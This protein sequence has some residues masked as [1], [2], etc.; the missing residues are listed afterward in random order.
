MCGLLCLVLGLLAIPPASPAEPILDNRQLRIRWD[1]T[2]G[3]LLEL[4]SLDQ[5]RNLIGEGADQPGL[6]ELRAQHNGNTSVLTPNQARHFLAEKPPDQPGS[7]R[8]I[9]RD[10]ARSDAPDLEIAVSVRL[11]SD[12][13]MSR[14]E[15][16]AKGLANLRLDQVSFPRVCG[17]ARQAHEMLAVPDHM[18]QLIPEPRD[19]LRARRAWDYP[20]PLSM[21][22]LAVYSVDGLGFYASSDDTEAFRKSFALECDAKARIHFQLVHY[23]E[24]QSQSAGNY[25]LPYHVELGAFRGDWLSAAEHYRD[26]ALKQPWARASRLQRGQVPEW[27]EKTAI[28]AWNRG[29]SPGVIPPAATLQ[30]AVGLPVSVFWHWWHGCAYDTGFPEY[31]P[32]REGAEPFQKALA[33]AHARQIHALVYMNQ[34]LWGMTTRSWL[35]EHAEQFAVKGPD[36]KIHPEVYNIFTRQP[37]AAMCL[38]T[39]FWRNKYARLAQQAFQD[40]GVDGIYMDQA[41]LNMTC[42]DATHGH[43]LGGGNYWMQGFHKLAADIRK[44]CMGGRTVALAGEGC[45]ETWIPDL[46]LMLTLEVSRERYQG[47]AGGAEPIPLFQAVYHPLAITFGNYSS[48]VMPPYDE[49]WPARTAPRQPMALLEPQYGRQFRLEQ[50]RAFVWGQQPTIANFQPSLLQTR[51]AETAYAIRLARMR[52]QALKYLLHGTYVRPPR[53]NVP[54]IPLE[55]LRMSIYTGRATFQKSYPAAL[56]SAWRAP[57]GDVAIVLASL[58]DR[59]LEL[60]LDLDPAQL[61]LQSPS[62][63]HR[64]DEKGRTPF[65]RLDR[66]QAAFQLE[67]PPDAATILEFSK[68]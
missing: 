11:E 37:C 68:N 17:L 62:Q 28:W 38:A 35:D 59:P 54:D 36:G 67:L 8:L 21:Q 25:T 33:D 24:S 66:R 20:G 6:W 15:L 3:R 22:F 32:P 5:N 49:L 44:R 55:I 56:A 7:V 27:V 2:D 47:L 12:Q 4:I 23:P 13:P 14:W 31:L 57:D 1:A 52:Y 50:A 39:S 63:I 41:C 18:G 16:A 30:D 45:G 51:P 29:R 65:G 26:W 60:S 48:L 19:H 64:L 43:S 53:L 40:L 46:D 34:R 9:W 10:F 61:G 58:V 42:Y